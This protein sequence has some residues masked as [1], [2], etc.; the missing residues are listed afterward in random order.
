MPATPVSCAKLVSLYFY[1]P[2]Q[3]IHWCAVLGWCMMMLRYLA[4]T[5]HWQSFTYYTSKPSAMPWATLPAIIKESLVL[6]CLERTHPFPHV[7][8]SVVESNAAME[9]GPSS[10]GKDSHIQ[11]QSHSCR[12]PINTI[13]IYI[14][15]IT[16]LQ[17]LVSPLSARS[18]L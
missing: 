7:H 8:D 14:P 11:G 1:L 15:T 9:N 5:Y 16:A 18:N 10:S 6:K 2:V 3:Q 13:Y 4:F 12:T 17:K